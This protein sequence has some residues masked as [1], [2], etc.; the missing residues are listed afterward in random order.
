MINLKKFSNQLTRKQLNRR[1]MLIF[2][3][4]YNETRYEVG[5][6]A[7]FEIPV[8]TLKDL[9][10]EGLADPDDCQNSAPS[11]VEIYNWCA[12]HNLEDWYA[13]GYAVSSKRIDCRVSIEGIGT[14]VPLRR[15][16]VGDFKKFFANADTLVGSTKMKAYCW[17][18]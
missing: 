3:T 10:I 1:D 8:N 15:G 9:L 16:V 5:G 12:E 11:I 6:I 7:H 18:D 14:Y 17:F 4:D 2:G 13:H